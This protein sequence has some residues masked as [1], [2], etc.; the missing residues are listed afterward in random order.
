M[1]SGIRKTKLTSF[2]LRS[3][4]SR[5]FSTDPT[6]EERVSENYDVVIVGGGPSGL[7]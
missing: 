4:N 2:K 5:K 7:K 1:N 3:S 6:K